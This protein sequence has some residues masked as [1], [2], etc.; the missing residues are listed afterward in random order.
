MKCA[1]WKCSF[2]LVLVLGAVLLTAVPLSAQQ[3]P[4]STAAPAATTPA[5]TPEMPKAV[6][7]KLAQLGFRAKELLGGVVV[8]G[9]VELDDVDALRLL[10]V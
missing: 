9:V 3:P 4:A 2:S 8:V 1:G 6:T 10:A 7:D 5:P